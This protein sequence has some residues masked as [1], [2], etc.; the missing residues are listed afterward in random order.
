M[1]SPALDKIDS[2]TEKIS[3][4]KNEIDEQ[5]TV[6]DAVSEIVSQVPSCE[7]TPEQEKGIFV[8]SR[9]ILFQIL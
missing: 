8:K 1:S 3:S 4:A 6:K 2:I 9:F 5:K 7:Q